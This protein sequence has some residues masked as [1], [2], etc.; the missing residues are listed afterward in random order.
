MTGNKNKNIRLVAD[1][2]APAAVILV[3]IA[4]FFLFMPEEPGTL[5]WTNMVYTAFLEILLFA[6]IVWLP[7]HGTSL[8]LKWMC[9]IYT[10]VYIAVSLVWMLLYGVLLCHWVPVKVY[11]AFIAVVT[12][13]WIFVG[14]LS[15]KVD[16]EHDTSTATLSDNRQR[17][18]EVNG[19]GEMYLQQFNLLRTLHPELGVA[20]QA[21]TSLCR[22]LATLSP[23]VMANSNAAG[24]IRIIASGL[25]DLLAEPTSDEQAMRLKEFSDKSLI[26]LNYLKKSVLK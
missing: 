5:F 21:V 20:S 18:N 24:Q 14:A 4:L 2:I 15:L 22:G 12:V 11:F 3:T 17:A 16:N 25:G 1:V 26:T 23:L 6:Y 8:A 9:G 10:V 7:V 19:S 13:L